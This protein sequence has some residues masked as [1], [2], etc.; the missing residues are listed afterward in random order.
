MPLWDAGVGFGS[1]AV[2]E[3]CVIF[4]LLFYF[5]TLHSR[6]LEKARHD[7]RMESEKQLNQALDELNKY[8][9]SLA[10][11]QQMAIKAAVDQETEGLQGRI[12]T[13]ESKLI[14][15]RA[16]HGQGKSKAKQLLRVYDQRARK[17]SSIAALD[18]VL[19]E[20]EEE[21]F[22]PSTRDDGATISEP[23]LEAKIKAELKRCDDVERM[24]L[25]EEYTIE[26]NVSVAEKKLPDSPP[27]LT[28]TIIN[29]PMHKIY[30]VG[31]LPQTSETT[32]SP[33][34]VQFG[35]LRDKDIV[36]VSCSIDGNNILCLSNEEELYWWPESTASHGGSS[37]LPR[38]SSV[39]PIPPERTSS[40]WQEKHDQQ[41]VLVKTM[42]LEKALHNRHIMSIAC[43]PDHCSIVCQ[44]GEVFAWGSHADGRLGLALAKDSTDHGYI[45]T[46]QLVSALNRK[47]IVQVEC[48]GAH[49]VARTSLGL[50]YTFGRGRA[51]R[52]G[53]GNEKDQMLPKMVAFFKGTKDSSTVEHVACGWGHTVAVT[54]DGNI[55][56]FGRGDNGQLGDLDIKDKLVPQ[57]VNDD[58][59]ASWKAFR[60]SCGYYHTIVLCKSRD[61]RS[62][63]VAV[64]SWG[65]GENGELGTGHVLRPIPGRVLFPFNRPSSSGREPIEMLDHIACGAYH[66]LALSKSGKVYVWGKNKDGCLGT[67]TRENVQTPM[68]MAAIDKYEVRKV[69]DAVCSAQFTLL[70]CEQQKRQSI[71]S[72]GSAGGIGMS[73]GVDSGGEEGEGR[74][75]ETT[76]DGSDKTLSM[77]AKQLE[78]NTRVWEKT[79][80]PKWEVDPLLLDTDK[81]HKYVYRGVPP[82]LRAR[83]WQLAIGNHLR[84]TPNLYKLLQENKPVKRDRSASLDN[85]LPRTFAEL[86]LFG[87]QGPFHETLKEVLETYVVF[88]PDLGYVQ[89]MS[90]IA[91]VLCLYQPDSFSAFRCLANLIVSEHF[92]PFFAFDVDN[93]N[94]YYEVYQAALEGTSKSLGKKFKDLNI[95][96]QLYIFNWFQTVFVRV[97][98]LRVASRVL[99]CF[100]IDGSQV[101]FRV[102]L[103]VV[104]LLKPRL[105]KCDNFEACYA[106]LMQ[107][108]DES[109]SVWS[110][111]V[112]EK[113]LF[114]KVGTVV[115]SRQTISKIR[116]LKM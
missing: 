34:W 70:L 55:Y 113:E 116:G 35:P 2:A 109:K 18:N 84:I 25:G 64:F 43:G 106:L 60:V 80:L 78:E 51:G 103:A 73:S 27:L 1:V 100:L 91:A 86:A 71:A 111:L 93:I 13:L 108:G 96:P 46:P 89:G 57:Q 49:T 68:K 104:L 42:V 79:I 72:F 38:N 65:L 21:T 44:S 32:T 59:I 99:D 41:P 75:V 4:G 10:S 85:D 6:T 114:K 69:V 48:G 28:A 87:D 76:N 33:E 54:K 77:T 90:Y 23:K 47:H 8:K 63:E 29:G 39:S 53:H 50:I 110:E 88:R 22:A 26:A 94:G 107:K 16:K 66:C 20:E 24:L 115:L 9:S 40:P 45:S 7:A 37:T 67:G 61:Q 56:C 3:L 31:K 92:F 74:F 105:K 95:E 102:A 83:V 12:T 11:K 17:L 14:K 5:K 19:E 82:E 58:A 36:Q 15:Y 81:V 52:L 62:D 30:G 97:L 101:L 98:P 112:T